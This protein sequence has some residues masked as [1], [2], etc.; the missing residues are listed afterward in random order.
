MQKWCIAVQNY[1]T[2]M[3]SRA[4]KMCSTS[5]RAKSPRKLLQCSEFVKTNHIRPASL[6]NCQLKQQLAKYA[7]IRWWCN[8]PPNTN[9]ARTMHERLSQLA[10]ICGT[11]LFT[12]DQS[13]VSLTICSVQ[14]LT[15]V[16]QHYWCSN[17]ISYW[18]TQWIR[19]WASYPDNQSSIPTETHRSHSQ[20][21]LLVCSRKS[22]TLHMDASKPSN[23]AYH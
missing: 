9:N 1:A 22:L 15:T 10:L 14:P 3:V 6:D 4:I 18:I 21:K 19:R 11:V 2:K 7:T 12:L 13:S 17:T 16:V 23:G 20:T 5:G 8:I